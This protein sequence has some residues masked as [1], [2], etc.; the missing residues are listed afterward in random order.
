MTKTYQ[1]G[2]TGQAFESMF[3]LAIAVSSVWVVAANV[4]APVLGWA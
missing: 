4:I 1:P 2:R 3:A